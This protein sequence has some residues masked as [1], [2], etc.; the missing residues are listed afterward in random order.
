MRLLRICLLRLVSHCLQTS[1]PPSLGS[2][3]GFSGNVGFS[4]HVA[5]LRPFSLFVAVRSPKMN[6][7]FSWGC[8]CNMLGAVA[9]FT[10]HH[11]GFTKQSL[12]RETSPPPKPPYQLQAGVI[13]IYIIIYR[14]RE[15]EHISSNMSQNKQSI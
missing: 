15:R 5:G 8:I 4:T 3:R 9:Q 1:H 2:G 14:E 7:I 12:I 6:Q 13:G 11:K 10:F